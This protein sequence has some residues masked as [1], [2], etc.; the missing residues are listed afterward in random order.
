MALASLERERPE[1]MVVAIERH[2]TRQRKARSVR[3][4]GIP[5]PKK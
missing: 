5:Q 4:C 1:L 3:L 2:E